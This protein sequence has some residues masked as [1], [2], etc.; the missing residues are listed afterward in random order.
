MFCYNPLTQP[1]LTGTKG[2][3]ITKTP[4]HYQNTHTLIKNPPSPKHP[5]IYQNPTIAKTP[6]LY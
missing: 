2:P 3:T 5:Y 1:F 6:T 4:T